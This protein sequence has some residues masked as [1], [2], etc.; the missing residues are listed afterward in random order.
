ML[1]TDY[2][3]TQ[4][5]G[6]I[7]QA[8]FPATPSPV[9]S[10]HK[11]ILRRIIT[12]LLKRCGTQ[13]ISSL[14]P[15]AH[16]PIITYIERVQRK[17]QNKIEKAKLRAILGGATTDG[18]TEKAAI[19]DLDDSSDDDSGDESDQQGA[20]G[21]AERR[22]KSAAPGNM[23]DDVAMG[24]EAGELGADEDELSSEEEDYY[25]GGGRAAVDRLQ[26]TGIDIPRVDDI[27]IVSKLSRKSEK[28]KLEGMNENERIEYK[29]NA[30]RENVSKIMKKDD[31]QLET[32]FVENPYIRLRE[33]AQ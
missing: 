19:D 9:I 26:A 33:K 31:F 11:L 14:L 15:A 23:D 8:L 29:L 2:L 27:P 21:E 10:K 28:E 25:G 32:H 30:N 1:S 20:G 17:Q 12:K 7:I 6:Q 18:T 16:R 5:A 3:K 13:L 22:E 4:M 24:G